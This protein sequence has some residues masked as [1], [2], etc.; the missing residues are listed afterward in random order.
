MKRI[1]SVCGLEKLLTEFH[2]H[3]TSS[4]GRLRICKICTNFK[5]KNINRKN[6]EKRKEYLKEYN[7]KNGNKSA[8]KWQDK[9][10]EKMRKYRQAYYLKNLEKLKKEMRE[11]YWRKKGTI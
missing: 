3:P 11:R 2:K 1:C 7:K 9:N 6:P 5:S 4:E 8:K 10:K